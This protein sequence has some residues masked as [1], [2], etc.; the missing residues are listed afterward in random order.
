M[1]KKKKPPN[2]GKRKKAF[3]RCISEYR[4]SVNTGLGCIPLDSGGAATERNNAK[5]NHLDFRADVQKVVKV[6]IKEDDLRV[7]FWTTYRW[8]SPDSIE[9]ELF[10]QKMLGDRRHAWEQRI[11]RIL[12]EREIFPLKKYFTSE[13][14]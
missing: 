6:V 14:R 4:N 13:R 9:R 10:A 3:D 11:G 2:Y 12:I 7:W 8:D 5:P 1:K